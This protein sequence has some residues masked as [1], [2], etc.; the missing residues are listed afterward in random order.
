MNQLLWGPRDLGVCVS[1]KFLRED[2]LAPSIGSRIE[3]TLVK[4]ECSSCILLHYLLDFVVGSGL[5]GP[6]IL[7]GP[8]KGPEFF[9]FALC[10]DYSE[11][12]FVFC[13]IC[14]AAYSKLFFKPTG[15]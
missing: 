14:D 13:D 3:S 4:W 8:K 10:I 5:N 1:K 9:F 2:M 11:S 6:S 15:G 12:V 7:T